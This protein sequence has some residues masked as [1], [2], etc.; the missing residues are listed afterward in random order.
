MT[1]L[2]HD[3]TPTKPFLLVARVGP[4]SLHKEWLTGADGRNFDLLLSAFSPG[5]ERPTG[6]GIFHE[7]RPGPKMYALGNLLKDRAEFL[8]KYEYIGF[9]DEDISTSLDNV[10]RIFELCATRALK[11]AQP[12]LTPDSYFS[13]AGLLQQKA[14]ELRSINQIE[15]MCPVFRVDVLFE[16]AP[17]FWSGYEVGMDLVWCNVAFEGPDDFAVLDCAP[18]THTLPVGA[19]KELNGFADGRPYEADIYAILK[20][21]DLPWLGCVPYYGVTKSGKKIA[22]R[23]LLMCAALPLAFS[24]TNQTPIWPRLMAVLTH[25]K[26]LLVRKPLNIPRTIS[27]S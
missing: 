27:A 2:A 20:D 5:V 18:V 3:W 4:N 19:R 26:H 25:W 14:F 17:L 15:M 7:L 21:Y 12:A 13:F 1:D 23:M 9:F 8:K 11:I 10:N 6:G 16:V 22:S 24:I